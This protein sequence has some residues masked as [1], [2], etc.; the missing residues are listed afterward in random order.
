[1]HSMSPPAVAAAGVRSCD[2]PLPPACACFRAGCLVGQVQMLSAGPPKAKGV[3]KGRKTVLSQLPTRQIPGIP[4]Q[5][6]ASDRPREEAN[7][8]PGGCPVFELSSACIP[9]DTGALH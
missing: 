1:M 6:L 2:S 3:K 8:M 9:T 7:G 5:V 4:P